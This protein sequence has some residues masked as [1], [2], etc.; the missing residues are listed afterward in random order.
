MH[1]IVYKNRKLLRIISIIILI[2]GG[3]MAYNFW[4]TEPQETISGVLCGIGVS[5]LVIFSSLKK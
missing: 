3:I 2:L 1:E 4:G 5:F